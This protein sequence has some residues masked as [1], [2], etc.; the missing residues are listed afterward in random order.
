MLQMSRMRVR[1][2]QHEQ[3]PLIWDWFYVVLSCMHTYARTHS[4]RLLLLTQC[5]AVAAVLHTDEQTKR[6]PFRYKSIQRP[7]HYTLSFSR[8]KWMGIYFFFIPFF[9]VDS[10]R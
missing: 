9:P 7:H 3:C 1:Q 4:V 6:K 8:F 5:Y 10:V 2:R